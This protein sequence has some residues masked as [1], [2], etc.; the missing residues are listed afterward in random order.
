MTLLV[1]RHLLRKR[2][3]REP[4]D[5]ATCFAALPGQASSRSKMELA[6]DT[7]RDMFHQRFN[8]ALP[9]LQ[10]YLWRLCSQILAPLQFIVIRACVKP[11]TEHMYMST[12][13]VVTY[14]LLSIS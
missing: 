2:A 7:P 10:I 6:L 14:H 4:R 11:L 12:A 13:T 8:H 5:T 1:E 3:E 9:F